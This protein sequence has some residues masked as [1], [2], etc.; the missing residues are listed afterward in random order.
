MS[1]N[2]LVLIP[3]ECEEILL[4]LNSD[5]ERGKLFKAILAYAF[6]GDEPS[7]FT[8]ALKTAF[9]AMKLIID[10]TNKEWF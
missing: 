8:G 2:K 6:S 3:G 9:I 4:T 7:D 10:N 5:E 1:K